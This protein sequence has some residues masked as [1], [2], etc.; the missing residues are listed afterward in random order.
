MYPTHLRGTGEG[1]ATNIGGRVLG[2]SAALAT[3]TIANAMPGSA[4]M[5]LAYAAACVGTFVHLVAFIG[6]F[7]LAEAKRAQL[8]D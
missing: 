8:P 6:T 3:A 7:S 4:S 5:Q 2:T 1:F